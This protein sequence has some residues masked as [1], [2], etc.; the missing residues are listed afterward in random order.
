M[1]HNARYGVHQGGKGRQRQ[2]ISRD[3]DGA[4]DCR[5]FDLLNPLGMRHRANVP[6]VVKNVA[7]VGNQKRRQ[8]AIVGPGTRD[9]GFVNGSRSFVEE[10][11]NGGDIGLSAVKEYVTLALLF[12][13]VEGMSVKKRPNELAANVLDSKFEMRVLINGVMAAIESGRA[14]VQALL[15]RDFV[16]SDQVRGVASS[17]GGNR[18]IEWMRKSVSEG[19]AWGRR[20]DRIRRRR[21]FEHARLDSHVE[22]SFYTLGEGRTKARKENGPAID[23]SV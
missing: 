2:Y 16:G 6:D 22:K 14:D 23:R 10:K 17:S 5:L 3:F 11:R 19:D 18:R 13:V 12:G 9:G 4:L 7:R 15:I 20:L 1:E 21:T 8:L